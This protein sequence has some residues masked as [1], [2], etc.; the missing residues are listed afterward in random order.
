MRPV[1][2]LFDDFEDGVVDTALKWEVRGVPS[3]LAESGGQLQL[4]GNSN[5]EY[6]GSRRTFTSAVA[7]HDRWVGLQ[8]PSTGLVLGY[9]GTDNRF[10]TRDVGSGNLGTT[11][12]PDVSA[13]NAYFDSTYPAIPYPFALERFEVRAGIVSSQIQVSK[14]CNSSICNTSP[15]A[16]STFSGP[17]FYVGYSTYAPQYRMAIVEIFVRKN[18]SPDPA[19]SVGPETE[20]CA[21]GD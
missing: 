17:S 1:F 7:I 11:V 15:R 12:D 4:A 16:L 14:Y 2:E 19:V 8:G 20:A 13:G 10:T 21:G 3:T 6:A 9:A 5:W 18:T